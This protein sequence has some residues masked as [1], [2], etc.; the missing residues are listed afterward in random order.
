M[1]EKWLCGHADYPIR[2]RLTKDRSLL[3]GFIQ[4][5]EVQYWLSLLRARAESGNL[6]KIHGSHDYR[7]ENI[8]GKCGI[9]GLSADCPEFMR[10]MGFILDFLR[11]Q[12]E[13]PARAEAGFGRIYAYRDYETVLAC[14]LPALGFQE[15]PAVRRI[16][17]KRID[18]LERFCRQKRYDIYIDGS[19]L[20]GVK[21]EWQ[22]FVIDPALYADGNIALPTMHDYI[23]FAG[24]Y[25]KLDAENR[26]KVETIA[27]WLF[28]DR[29][30]KSS[31]GTAISMPPAGLTR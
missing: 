18:L 26:N 4:N 19:E 16:A 13:I 15:E 24:M 28:D 6:G 20:R 7:M 22:P 17:L 10:N 2:Y 21:K 23:L 31:G 11:R 30:K 5:D 3:E 25:E 9:L 12:P 8:L 1:D 27:G 29:Y 14:F